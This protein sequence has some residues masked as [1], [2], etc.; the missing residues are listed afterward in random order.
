MPQDYRDLITITPTSRVERLRNAY[1]DNFKH[2]Q[3]TYTIYADR[4]IALQCW[5]H[6]LR[7]Y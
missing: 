4:A 6:G 3:P 5:Y 7:R 2:S 1:L